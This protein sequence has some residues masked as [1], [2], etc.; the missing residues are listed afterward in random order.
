MRCSRR[1][2]RARPGSSRRSPATGSRLTCQGGGLIWPGLAGRPHGRPRRPPRRVR[3]LHHGR[4]PGMARQP[5][6]A[7][8]SLREAHAAAEEAFG[9]GSSEADALGVVF[10]AIRQAARPRCK[11]TAAGLNLPGR[12][13]RDGEPQMNG[14]PGR[15]PE[16]QPA[17]APARDRAGRRGP[18]RRGLHG[19]GAPADA[20][21]CDLYLASRTRWKRSVA[22]TAP[23]ADRA[24]GEVLVDAIRALTEARACGGLCCSRVPTRLGAPPSAHGPAD[25]AEFITLA[26]AGAAGDVGSV[27]R[28][29]EGR[30]GRG[31]PTRYSACCCPPSARTRRSCC[32]IAPRPS[33]WC[34]GRRRTVGPW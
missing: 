23:A 26:V 32:G 21:D 6:S 20:E 9:P 14:R 8:L 28:A 16:G 3:V 17:D 31:R 22:M 12:T 5:G 27:D 2:A 18:R 4:P 13:H 29:L 11:W 24:Q 1:R 33:G 34:C 30:P 7:L 25:W 10:A 15:Q 19:P